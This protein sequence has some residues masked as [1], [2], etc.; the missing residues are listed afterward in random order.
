MAAC[1]HCRWKSVA[2]NYDEPLPPTPGNG[3]VDSD[4]PWTELVATS[5]QLHERE[6]SGGNGG[7][8][9]IGQSVDLGKAWLKSRIE[10]VVLQVEL[11]NGNT[12]NAAVTFQGTPWARSDLNTDGNVNATDWPLFFPNLLTNMSSLTDVQRALGRRPRRRWRQRRH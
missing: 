9:G 2:E 3:T 11:T 6:Q 12:V 5:L 8:L 7:T 10:D 1:F 4:D